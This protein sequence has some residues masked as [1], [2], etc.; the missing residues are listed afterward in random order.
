MKTL[1]LEAYSGISGDMTVAA[2]LDLGAD[3]TVLREALAS[4]GA[5]G[6]YIEITKV[7]KCGITAC[8]FNV[9]LHDAHELEHENGHHNH[10]HEHHENEHEHNHHHEHHHSHDHDHKNS[11]EHSHEH[12]EHRG[13]A[14][15]TAMIDSAKITGSAKSLAKKIFNIVAEAEAKV[16]GQP[17]DEVHFHEV[18]AVD[19]IVD[20]VGAA[21]C[22]DNLGIEKI[23]CTP[24]R[25][26]Q[27]TVW[28][29]HG[30]VPV[31]APA[32]LEI[33]SAHKIPLVITQ[34]DGEMVTPTGAAIVAALC[35]SSGGDAAANGSFD[36]PGG[37]T[38]VK[39]GYGAGKKDFNVA[40]VL[41]ASIVETAGAA[42]TGESDEV[43]ELSCNIDDMSAEQTARAC[44]VFLESGALDCWLVPATMKKGRQGS[45]LKLLIKPS[46]EDKFTR[47][48]FLH[49]STIGV[50]V[51]PLR[52][53]KMSR[54]A[55]Q[56][57][58]RYGTLSVKECLYGDICKTTV[59]YE[60][61]KELAIENGIPITGIYREADKA[62]K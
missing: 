9:I 6:Y 31:P 43:L 12:H 32:T 45:V 26:G 4:L 49:T 5:K 54:R 13:L 11:H 15:I 50:R 41:R 27:G 34:N 20:I 28:C 3:E 29:G 21:V 39:T 25:E 23:I 61:A 10:E 53:R 19:S 52:R 42:S 51:A 57:E 46:D 58:T 40:N 17:V 37:M 14:E 60:S 18:G 24:L 2:L 48:L 8:D 7:K 62:L 55:G 36:V 38:V 59:E 22:V 33:V 44:E 47:L 1:Y 30:R 56:V 35:G 16:H